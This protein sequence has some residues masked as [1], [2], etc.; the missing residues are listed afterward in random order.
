MRN[1]MFPVRAVRVVLTCVF[2]Q[3][4]PLQGHAGKWDLHLR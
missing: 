2:G 3:L 1:T 4:M